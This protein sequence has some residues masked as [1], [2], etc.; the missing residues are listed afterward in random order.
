MD[1]DGDAMWKAYLQRKRGERLSEAARAWRAFEAAVAGAD[2][3]VAIDF[4]HLCPDRGRAD[5]LCTQLSA[6]Y[7]VGLE[8]STDGYWLAKGTT[9]PYG[10]GLCEARHCAWV[11]F[12][13]DVAESHGCVFS[14]WSIDVPSRG[15]VVR[16]E[17]FERGG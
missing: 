12:M 11:E 10:V 4:V 14:T 6:H 2:T 17:A 3:V 7:A 8:P 13:C 1:R 16:S 15:L 9:R 5:A